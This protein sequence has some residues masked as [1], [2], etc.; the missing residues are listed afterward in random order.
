MEIT[1]AA[2]GVHRGSGGRGGVAGGGAGTEGG[3]AVGYFHSVPSDQL[4][5]SSG[6]EVSL[7]VD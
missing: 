4:P 7:S 2:A 3:D 5:D 1:D 6:I